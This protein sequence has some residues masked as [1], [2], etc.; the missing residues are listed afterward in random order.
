MSGADS[1]RYKDDEPTKENSRSL[2]EERKRKSS[3]F[4]ETLQAIKKATM[5][6][7]EDIMQ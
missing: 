5:S 2:S 6:G 3:A 1:L 7:L 4:N